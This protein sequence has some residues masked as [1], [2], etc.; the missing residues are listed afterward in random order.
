MIQVK[1][2]SYFGLNFWY[3]EK[4]KMGRTFK[5]RIWKNFLGYTL[6]VQDF[7]DKVLYKKSVRKSVKGITNG[8][9]FAILRN[10]FKLDKEK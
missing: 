1:N 9:C 5:I 4:V 3:H 7:H 10:E 2:G 8:E 6:K